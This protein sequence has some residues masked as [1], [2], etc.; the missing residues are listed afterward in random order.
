MP[1]KTKLSP[2][3]ARAL[4]LAESI[5]F[6]PSFAAP[7][8]ITQNIKIKKKTV[9]NL[10]PHIIF[11][12]Y[13]TPLTNAQKFFNSYHFFAVKPFNIVSITELIRVFLLTKGKPSCP[14]RRLVTP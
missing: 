5:G 13:L 11:K 4:L 7:N 10:S 2:V 12:I 3:A 6:N 14:M 8:N 9:I 1:M